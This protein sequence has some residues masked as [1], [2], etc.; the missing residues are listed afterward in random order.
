MSTISCPGCRETISLPPDLNQELVCP[1]CGAEFEVRAVLVRP[2]NVFTDGPAEPTSPAQPAGEEVSA[3]QV[4][5]A[6]MAADVPAESAPAAVLAD[7]DTEE[8]E[9]DEDDVIVA[10]GPE[11]EPATVETQVPATEDPYADNEVSQA[12]V[13][14]MV[15]EGGA[16]LDEPTD[17][18]EAIAAGESGAEAG[19]AGE[20]EPEAA[21]EGEEHAAALA[22]MMAGAESAG[23]ATVAKSATRRAARRGPSIW[24]H[25]VGVVGGGF[26]GLILG[27]YILVWVFGPQY[28]FL[29]LRLPGLSLPEDAEG[30]G[31]SGGSSEPV[32]RPF[33]S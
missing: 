2:S 15:A 31:G 32:I 5:G 12:A 20:V 28:N 4:S 29:E 9:D 16:V 17:S 27:Y 19:V 14:A 3:A 33:R 22:G 26:I 25:L 18:S 11:V 13:G 1:L 10:A 6:E 23:A 7:F 30:D 8:D 24:A 21:A